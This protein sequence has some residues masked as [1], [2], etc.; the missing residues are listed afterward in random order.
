MRKA[1][2]KD[3]RRLSS[4]IRESLAQTSLTTRA[5]EEELGIGHGN[6]AHLL[7][8]QLELKLRHLLSVARL[9]GVPPHR[10]VELGCPEALG[11]ATRDVT[12]LVETPPTAGGI[13]HLSLEALNG[14]IREIVREEIA[15]QAAAAPPSPASP[16]S[17]RKTAQR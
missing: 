11:G 1:M 4:L 5:L 16:A 2:D 10:L 3:L 7:S 6:L 9:L 13:G 12:D 17:R 15:L 8:G 14:R